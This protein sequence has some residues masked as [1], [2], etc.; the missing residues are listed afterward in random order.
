MFA[1]MP[2]VQKWRATIEDL[3]VSLPVAFV[4]KVALGLVP[5]SR[6]LDRQRGEDV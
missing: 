6:L 3:L 1:R 4:G 2:L 5:A